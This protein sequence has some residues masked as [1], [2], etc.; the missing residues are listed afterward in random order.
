MWQTNLVSYNDQMLVHAL[1][2]L[3]KRLD[4]EHPAVLLFA[5]IG[6]REYIAAL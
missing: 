5:G 6:C 2:I 3:V 1:T 4:P